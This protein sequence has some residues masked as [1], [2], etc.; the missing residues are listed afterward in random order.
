VVD[1]DG[2][3]SSSPADRSR[4]PP[5]SRR[6]WRAWAPAPGRWRR[7]RP[8]TRSRRPAAA[9]PPGDS[10]WAAQAL[11]VGRHG[12][13]QRR[14]GAAAMRAPG[15]GTA[16]HRDWRIGGPAWTMKPVGSIGRADAGPLGR[17]CE[18]WS[19][20]LPTRSG[21][22][23]QPSAPHEASCRSTSRRRC[24]GCCS[25][26]ARA[27][28]PQEQGCVWPGCRPRTPGSG[29]RAGLALLAVRAALARQQAL[30]SRAESAR[31]MRLASTYSIQLQW[32]RFSSPIAAAAACRTC[33]RIGLRR[34][35]PPTSTPPARLGG[36]RDLALGLGGG[37]LVPDGHVVLAGRHVL[38]G[39]GAARAGVA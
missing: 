33:R 8:A 29:P 4:W 18:A 12:H 5:S 37:A 17:S 38:D 35:S 11:L 22:T 26:G 39:E 16:Q 25:G 36:H 7:S 1:V 20:S 30:A 27:V 13:A 34:L 19:R 23:A 21:I 10:R 9:P 6:A 14:R 28:L 32:I 2:G 24:R 15:S 31:P 3:G